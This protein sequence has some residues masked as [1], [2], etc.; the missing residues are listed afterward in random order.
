MICYFIRSSSRFGFQGV[1]ERESGREREREM[2]GINDGGASTSTEAALSSPS[3]SGSFAI[4]QNYPLIS[5]F[6]AF[7]I[8]QLFKF[9]TSW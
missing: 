1:V 5:A 4:L 6:V 8:A 3:T 7:A 2:R 9:F